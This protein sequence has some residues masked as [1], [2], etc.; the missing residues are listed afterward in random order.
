MNRLLPDQR[1]LVDQKLVSNNGWFELRLFNDG[2][3]AVVR[4]QRSQAVWASPSN[5]GQA[6]YFAVMQT[7][8]NF[9]AYTSQGVAYWASNT[10]GNPGAFLVLEADG[11]LVVRGTGNQALWASSSGQDLLSPTIRYSDASGFT[12]DETSESW[13]QMC[14]AFPCFAGLHWPGYSTGVVEDVVDGQPIVIQWWNGWCQKFLGSS[15]F[16]GGIGA[17]VGI[18]RRI[19]GKL[20]PLSLPFLPSSLAAE[21]LTAYSRLSDHELWWPFPEL[22]ASIEFTLTNPVTGLPFFSAGPETSYWLTKWMDE[23][24]FLNYLRAQGR[25]IAPEDFRLDYRIKGRNASAAPWLL[26]L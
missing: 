19:P 20:P 16:P 24:A 12:Y 25:F 10:D 8:G 14:Q 7:D 2:G 9:V 5:P 15:P 17:E 18:Y 26:L 4:V 13:K 11:N 6:G 3:L 1:L 23:G 21:L 22:G